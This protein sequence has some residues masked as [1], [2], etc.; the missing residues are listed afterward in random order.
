MNH[1]IVNSF[2]FF[3]RFQTCDERVV[4]A[5]LH[6]RF[7]FSSLILSQYLGV[8]P[9]YNA[10]HALHKTVAYFHCACVKDLVLGA[11]PGKVLIDELKEGFS[12]VCLCVSAEWW[13]EPCNVP[14]PVSS[15]FVCVFFGA[16]DLLP[17]TTCLEGPV[18]GWC[19]FVKFCLVAQKA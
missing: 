1:L 12:D 17:V 19:R 15:F 8:V 6:L 14:W 3:F 18:V 11:G 5:A 7:L 2:L 16:V 13:V 4:L 10:F 9:I